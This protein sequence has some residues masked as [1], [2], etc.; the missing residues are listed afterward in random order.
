[1][2]LFDS[3]FGDVGDEVDEANKNTQAAIDRGR[4]RV[5]S[6][7]ARS[8][9]ERGALKSMVNREIE[10]ARALGRSR[11]NLEVEASTA[12]V[13]ARVN[14]ERAA[15]LG[16][17][18]ATGR[19]AALGLNQAEKAVGEVLSVEKSARLR[20][21]VAS[22]QSIGQFISQLGQVSQVGLSAEL[23]AEAEQSRSEV[24]AVINMGQAS[25]EA[26]SRKGAAIRG[27]IAGAVTLAS[28]GAGGVIAGGIMEGVSKTGK[29]ISDLI[30]DSFT[31]YFFDLFPDSSILG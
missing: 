27:A 21:S 7:I 12:G 29:G 8:I 9:A 2:R 15:A 14:A 11:D 28:G 18:G 5:D 25:I 6:S 17:A 13:R 31:D 16:T 24:E 4:G 19:T 1:M 10:N 30:P 3:V 22:S 20:R 26:A 23:Q